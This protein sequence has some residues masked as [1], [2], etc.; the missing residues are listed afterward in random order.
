GRRFADEKKWM[1]ARTELAAVMAL[2]PAN[3][4]AKQLLD[5]VQQHVEQE[6]KIRKDLDEAKKSFQDK[7]YQAALWKL[8]RLPKDSALGDVALYIRNAWFDWAIVGLKGGDATDAKQKLTETLG[9]DPL[10]ADAKKLL[11]FANVY[12]SKPKDRVY[13]SFVDS[14]R[15]RAIDQK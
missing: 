1:E 4:E 11:E 3:F 6:L 15:P 2:D 5:Q 8:Y 12:G 9:V 14:L 10:D 13:Y 7:D